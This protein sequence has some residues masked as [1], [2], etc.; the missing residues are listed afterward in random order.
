MSF[1]AALHSLHC[2]AAVKPSGRPAVANK[3]LLM[4][5]LWKESCTF[6][7]WT[8]EESRPG[9]DVLAGR[10]VL[11]RDV[12]DFPHKCIIERLIDWIC[13]HYQHQPAGPSHTN[14]LMDTRNVMRRPLAPV[15]MTISAIVVCAYNAMYY[16]LEVESFVQLCILFCKQDCGP[17]GRILP[18][19]KAGLYKIAIPYILNT[20]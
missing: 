14:F 5:E 7:F 19:K 6:T 18:I 10:G 13:L 15:W 2:T 4:S 3:T 9:N 11:F 16:I 17:T 12:T 1:N 8:R 20:H